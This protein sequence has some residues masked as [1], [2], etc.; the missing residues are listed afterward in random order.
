MNNE[1]VSNKSSSSE[2][3]QP[4]SAYSSHQFISDKKFLESCLHFISS[5]FGGAKD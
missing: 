3:K 2:R 1:T 5:S 4:D